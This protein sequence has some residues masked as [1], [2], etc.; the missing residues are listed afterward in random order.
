MPKKSKTRFKTKF[1]TREIYE[2]FVSKDLN[3]WQIK[4]LIRSFTEKA[5]KIPSDLESSQ[6]E[7][8]KEEIISYTGVTKYERIR[9]RRKEIIGYGFSG[10]TKSQLLEQ[11]KMLKAYISE[12]YETYTTR[13]S[14]KEG[15][16]TEQQNKAWKSFCDDYGYVPYKFY[17]KA[18]HAMNSIADIIRY[19]GSKTVASMMVDFQKSME[20]IRIADLARQVWNKRGAGSTPKQLANELL[21][22]VLDELSS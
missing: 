17:L 14:S 13:R 4:S 10:K 2:Y 7:E 8:L 12:Y 3:V 18:V 19:F 15:P 21:D 11:L 22:A 9:G 6:M 16:R 1:S 20:P 5:N